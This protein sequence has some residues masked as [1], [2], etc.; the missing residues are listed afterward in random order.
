MHDNSLVCKDCGTAEDDQHVSDMWELFEEIPLCCDCVD[1][2][3][4]AC[5]PPEWRIED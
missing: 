5:A 2:R 3:A 1:R 4:G